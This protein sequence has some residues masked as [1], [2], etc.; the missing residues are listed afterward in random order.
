[1]DI[2][3][4]NLSKVDEFAALFQNMKIFTDHINIDINEERIYIQT[5]DNCKILLLEVEIPEIEDMSEEYENRFDILA[6]EI[7]ELKQTVLSLQTYTMEVNKML[8][9]E[10]QLSVNL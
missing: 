5:M 4:N 3:L 2:K 1:M 8:L 9:N 6:Q 10:R 7:S